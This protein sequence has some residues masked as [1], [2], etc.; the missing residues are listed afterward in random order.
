[1]KFYNSYDYIYSDLEQISYGI[2][3]AA[4]IIC[5]ILLFAC[6]GWLVGYI[7]KGIGLYTMAKRQGETQLWM[8]FV[9]VVRKYLQGKL[10][11]DLTL[12]NKTLRDTA[13]WFA[14]FPV[15]FGVVY[16]AAATAAALVGGVTVFTAFLPYSRP[17]IGAGRTF[18]LI[19]LILVCVVASIAYEAVYKTFRV[20]VNSRIYKNVTSDS[21]ATAHAVLGVFVPL[22]ES[23]CFFALRNSVRS[24][25]PL[26]LDVNDGTEPKEKGPENGSEPEAADHVSDSAETP[27]D[28]EPETADRAPDIIYMPEVSENPESKDVTAGMPPETERSETEPKKDI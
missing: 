14:L 13:M 9:P 26:R 10:S 11:G 20:L 7:L 23:I 25:E 28:G 19:F 17:H 27:S 8:A 15:I 3:I 1:M 5:A 22:Y 18:V 12:K 6:I 4:A 16:S 24:G 2:G 21:M